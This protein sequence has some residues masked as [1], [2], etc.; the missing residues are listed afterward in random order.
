MI[1]AAYIV[2][3]RC[4]GAHSL[5]QCPWPAGMVEAVLAANVDMLVYGTAVTQ[6]E[7]STDGDITVRHVPIIEWIKER[8][9]IP[10][11]W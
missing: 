6:V 5:S 8:G 7:M 11:P 3:T 1:Y 2:C 4:A 9:N 10:Y